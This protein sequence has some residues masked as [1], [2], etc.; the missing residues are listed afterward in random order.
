MRWDDAGLNT[1]DLEAFCLDNGPGGQRSKVSITSARQ[2]KSTKGRDEFVTWRS[3]GKQH[4]EH[5]AVAGMSPSGT[6]PE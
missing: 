6:K 2:P 1:M 3:K 4:Q 5:M